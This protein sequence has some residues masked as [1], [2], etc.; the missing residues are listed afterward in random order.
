[1]VKLD[2]DMWGRIRKGHRADIRHAEKSVLINWTGCDDVAREFA[3]YQQ[4]HLLDAGRPTRPQA[5]FDLMRSWIPEHGLLAVGR[6]NGQAMGA[7]YFIRH[8][9]GAYYAS[10]ARHPEAP[11]GIAHLLVWWGMLT[12]RYTAKWLDLGPVPS[13]DA[14]IKEGSIAH[15]KK[16]FGAEV[17]VWPY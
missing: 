7:A 4:L 8:G 3:D 10:A 15:F 11:R 13:E 16:G 5:T 1:M 2:A 17:R 14:T 12:L 9:E 6:V